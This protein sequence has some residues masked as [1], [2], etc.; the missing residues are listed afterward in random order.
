KEETGKDVGEHVV[1]TLFGDQQSGSP[2]P[3]QSANQPEL[4]T[5]EATALAHAP[6]DRA[7]LT[8][9]PAVAAMPANPVPA[10]GASTSATAQAATPAP[11]SRSTESVIPDHAPIPLARGV[12]MSVAAPA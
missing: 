2:S 4:T 8:P 11:A 3:G 6:V 9:L 10:S 7:E 5:Q 12:G 1:A